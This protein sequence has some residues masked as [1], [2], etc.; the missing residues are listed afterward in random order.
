MQ[1]KY[2]GSV[3][4]PAHNEQNVISRCLKALTTPTAT[5]EDPFSLEIVVVC[6][7][8]TDQ[9]AEVASGF[10][11]VT[12]I[13][14]PESSKVAALNVGDSAVTTF[15]RIYLDADSELANQSARSLLRKAGDQAGPAIISATVKSD[16]RKCSIFARS[17]T[18][19][20]MRTSFGELGIVGRGVYTLNRY[21][22]ARFESFPELMGDDFFVASLFN[23]DEQIIDRCATVVIRPPSDL[24]SLVRVR[25]RIYYGNKE[26]GRER[27]RHI[28]RH[29]GWRNV[30]YAARRARSFGE[31]FDLAVYTGVNLAAKRSASRMARSGASPRWER[32]DSSRV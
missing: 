23:A 28:S 22:R 20:A 1:V 21:G 32:D 8:C 17:F 12:V 14:I 11:N 13:E 27:A 2:Q 4:I 25:S 29:P 3:V 6:N 30:A 19:C 26:A 31:F 10:S 18:R 9:T 7:G 5:K 16:M 15:P 24:H